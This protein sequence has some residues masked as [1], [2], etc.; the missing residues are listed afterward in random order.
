MYLCHVCDA[1][2]WSVYLLLVGFTGSEPGVGISMIWKGEIKWRM[3]CSKPVL[4]HM[5][6]GCLS[7]SSLCMLRCVVYFVPKYLCQYVW[8][9]GEVWVYFNKQWDR[10]IWTEDSQSF[11]LVFKQYYIS[12]ILNYLY[13]SPKSFS[14]YMYSLNQIIILQ[15]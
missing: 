2:L 12:L 8:C 14:R 7:Q 6:K 9:V 3:S 13:L 4:G 5:A 11:F 10:L 1:V 15:L